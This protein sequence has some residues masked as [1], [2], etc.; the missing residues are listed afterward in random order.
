[1]G[2]NSRKFD[3]ESFLV[4]IND[5]ILI[6]N[7]AIEDKVYEVLNHLKKAATHPCQ[8][9]IIKKFTYQYIGRMKKFC[10]ADLNVSKQEKNINDR[11][12]RIRKL[13]YFPNTRKN[14]SQRTVKTILKRALQ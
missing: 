2:C 8:E 13:S 4:I 9:G 3:K 5:D 11:V 14:K 7:Q 6:P 1:M 12:R 10:F